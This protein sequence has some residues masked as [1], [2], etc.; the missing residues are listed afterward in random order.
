MDLDTIFKAYDVRGLVPEQLDDEAAR[1][2]GAAFARFAGAPRVAVGRDCRESSP[3]LAAALI[4]GITSQG[5]AVDDLGMITTDMV[6][7][8]AGSLD[9]PGV[10]ITA[11]HNPKG[12]NGIKMCLAGAAPVG[13]ETGLVEIKALAAE[14][15]PATGP[16][17]EVAITGILE[18]YVEHVLSI[19]DP[20]TFRDLH[21]GADG[22]NGVAGV[23]VPAVFDRLPVRLRGLYL[24]PDGA[25]PN[26]HPDPLR[27]ENLR[28]LLAVMRDE[29]LDLGVAFDGDADRAFFID[30]RLHPLPGSTM[31]AMVAAWYLGRNPGASIVHN[32]IC[33]R[34][35]PETVIA[36]GGTPVR[37]RVG[38]SFIKGVMKE[39]GAVFGGEH[40]GHYYFKD[41]YR[42]DSGILAMLVLLQ[43]LSE[44]GR[45]L[46]EIRKDFEPYAQS[47]EINFQVHDQAGSTAEV[48]A[49]FD[50]EVDHLDGLTV[51]W[52]DRWFNLR[53]SNT[54]PVLRLNVEAPDAGLVDD[55]VAAVQGVLEVGGGVRI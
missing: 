15:L 55:L 43:L 42:A 41:N 13:E 1:R 40:S 19:V 31:T 50:G 29:H 35:V 5:V 47:G 54:E 39:T 23:A 24:E 21:V 44:D 52:D 12:Y 9:E 20:D 46:S 33:S 49:A 22:G 26:H 27:P 6:Y 11:S 16:A 45:P 34:A 25:F 37:T 53:P 10:M 32:L 38:H 51:S 7:F 28:D 14:G 17:G 8:A 2:I 36:H 18:G 3:G 30:D 48:A 4:E